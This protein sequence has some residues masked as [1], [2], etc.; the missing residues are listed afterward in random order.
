[1]AARLVPIKTA[2]QSKDFY[3]PEIE[4]RLAREVESP[5]NL[6]IDKLIRSGP[7]SPEERLR[8]AVY[9][10]TMIKRVPYRRRKAMEM[11]PEVIEAVFANLHEGLASLA[12]RE[13]SSSEAV[14]RRL[15]EMA[16]LRERYLVEPPDS[17]VEQI[18][19][20][21]V[22]QR[23]VAAIY[24]MTWR[25]VTTR[26]LQLF[27]TCDNPAYYF[28]SYG[29]GSEHSELVFP[30]STTHA[31]HGSFQGRAAGLIFA[32]VPERYVREFR[33]ANSITSRSAF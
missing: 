5:C 28:E 22:S 30:L 33:T 12:E 27:A 17:M 19:L 32:E 21:W 18:R 4:A 9:I 1:M 31:I 8:L 6:V 25:V 15:R 3:T 2:A 7:I 23:L 11:I 16:A 14:A 10:G 26:G 29:V 24:G 13:P 20:P